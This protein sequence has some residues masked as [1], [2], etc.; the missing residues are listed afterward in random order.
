MASTGP[1]DLP[2]GRPVPLPAGKLPV[3]PADHSVA[4]VWNEVLL[5]AIRGDSP[6]PSVHARNL[7]HL[8]GALYDAWA[9]FHDADTPL[10]HD[11]SPMAG[12]QEAV[13]TAQSYAAYRLL[14]HRF[15]TS[16]GH[17]ESQA[18]FDLVMETQGLDPDFTDTDG[19][20]PAAL[21]NRI[22]ASYIDHGLADGA[23]EDGNYTDTVGYNPVN[24]PMLVWLPGTGGLSDINVWQPLIPPGAAG[25]QAF[26]TPH[27]YGVAP[28]ALE[29][30]DGQDVYH[31]PGTPPQLSGSGD[32][33]FREHVVELIAFGATLDPGDGETVNISPA[34]AGNNSL[35]ANDGNGHGVNP[36]TG[37]PY[38][39]NVVL[40]GDWSRVLAEFWAD[41]PHSSTPPGHWN[42]IANSVSEA[43]ERRRI[44][45][46]GAAVSALEWDVKLYL[47]LNGALHDAAIAG[48]EV[49]YLY[50]SSRPI[51]LIRGMA[52]RGQS[53]D[54]AHP[55]FDPEGLPLVPDLVELITPESSAAGQRHEH[56]ADHVGEIAIR[57]WLGHPQDP[58]SEIGGVDWI[59]GVEW[60]PYQARNF[61]TPP[62][63]GYV[64]GHSTFSRAAA[65]VLTEFTGNPYFP[66]GYGEFRI[67]VGGE[68]ELDFEHGPSQPVALQWATYYDAA[69]EAGLS[70]VYGG[71]HPTYDDLPGRI[72]G[73][74]V[75]LDAYAQARALFAPVAGQDPGQGQPASVPVMSRPGL[76]LLG[77]LLLL[78][79]LRASR[80]VH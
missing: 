28:F 31:D 36:A 67:E 13:E 61:V 58:E 72:I 16:P 6:R 39:D 63:P 2:P 35:G 32:A 15:A 18:M 24:L 46:E 80:P 51:T 69:D 71:I 78:L 59:R 75:G 8:S 23:N 49:K 37:Q 77:G 53:S 3:D 1:V 52:E 64:S 14:S 50:E 42:E 45:G 20:T 9:A 74:A 70:R 26:L 25:P 54:P 41:G 27:W 65:E 17:T 12:D 48:W 10:L 79:G 55:S 62:F 66:G 57:G 76:L 11:E 60:L 30:T 5:V 19:D 29:H 43:V 38:P 40:R 56:L 21:G 7:F 34:V 4:R 22:A 68:F 33:E 47:A 44:G 73:S